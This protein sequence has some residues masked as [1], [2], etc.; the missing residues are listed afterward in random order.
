M[1][2]NNKK[3]IKYSFNKQSKIS[4]SRCILYYNIIFNVY[5]RIKF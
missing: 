1:G 4:C 3:V 2:T 5:K